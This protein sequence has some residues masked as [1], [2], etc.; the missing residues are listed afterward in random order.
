MES[1]GNS[2]LAA[3]P[4][5]PS[6]GDDKEQNEPRAGRRGKCIHIWAPENPLWSPDPLSGLPGPC[7]QPLGCS[8]L[9]FPQIL[10]G[11]W[12]AI[13]PL[14]GLG[15]LSL[16]QDSSGQW[17]CSCCRWYT[18]AEMISSSRKWNFSFCTWIVLLFSPQSHWWI[19]QSY[20][21]KAVSLGP[22][23]LIAF[24]VKVSQF[25]VLPLPDLLSRW[26]K[27]SEVRLSPW[28]W[29]WD[30]DARVCSLCWLVSLPGPW[31]SCIGPRRRSWSTIC[32]PCRHL[33]PWRPVAL[34]P[35]PRLTPGHCSACTSDFLQAG[36]QGLLG[37]CGPGVLGAC[38]TWV[39]TAPMAI[40]VLPVRHWPSA[41]LLRG[42]AVFLGFIPRTGENP[43]LSGIHYNLSGCF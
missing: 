22:I 14:K 37:G 1:T 42:L 36:R 41:E 15:P 18:G 19:I 10:L 20:M 11:S 29:S 23:T 12:F 38:P 21:T 13:T 40:S 4:C 6:G 9:D 25:W 24:E 5:L 2:L 16:C 31:A 7:P 27:F 43:F 17:P 8:Q 30:G 32:G 39:Q 35:Q 28:H 26:P 34:S 3:F 33:C